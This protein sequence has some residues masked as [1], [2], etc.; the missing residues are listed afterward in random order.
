MMF[1]RTH[2]REQPA[3]MS[4]RRAFLRKEPAILVPSRL[5]ACTKSGMRKHA[6]DAKMSC[7][8]ALPTAL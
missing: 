4:A 2:D 6:S 8:R 3:A 7:A 5:H 1:E